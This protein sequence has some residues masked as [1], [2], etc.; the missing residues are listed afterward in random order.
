MKE[1]FAIF[2]LFTHLWGGNVGVSPTA[3]IL[4]PSV[5][6]VGISGIVIPHH[7]I[8][9]IKRQEF[10][11]HV[12]DAFFA[13]SEPPT[14]IIVSPNHFSAGKAAIQ[15]TTKTWMLA[16]GTMEPDKITVEA[17][18]RDHIADD[19]PKDVT[20]DHGI[21]YVLADIHAVF[22]HAQIVPIIVRQ[23]APQTTIDSLDISLNTTCPSCL[24]I[25]SVDFS[26]YQP[27]AL[28]DIHDTVSV[29]ALE[30]VDGDT[31]LNKTEVDSPQALYL[32]SRWATLHNTKHFNLYGHTN[33]GVLL[34]NPD[35]ETTTH[36]FG[37][38][39]T[40]KPTVPDNSVTFT[41]AG[42]IMLA[43]G[44]ATKFGSNYQSLFAELGDRVFWGV[45]A[46]FAN[47]EGA[48]TDQTSIS[49]KV[50]SDLT[51]IFPKQALAAL[52]YLHLRAVSLANNHALNDEQKGLE[53]SRQVL[54]NANVMSF[55]D[56]RATKDIKIVH[57]DGQGYHL[58][59]IGVLAINESTFLQK[60][61]IDQIKTIKKDPTNKVLIYPHWGIEYALKHSP[62]QESLAHSW[63]DAGADAIIGTHPHV[64]QDMEAYHGRPIIYSLGNFI[65]D[66][67]TPATTQYGLIVSGK[68]TDTG[69]DLVPSPIGFH[70]M[71]PFLM[72]GIEKQTH[73]NALFSSVDKYKKDTP[74]STI[75]NFPLK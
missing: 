73:L 18:L 24:M 70:A 1:L 67:V 15:T 22:P 25:A 32:L 68:F 14:V 11:A 31:L 66:Q 71:K 54:R 65:F 33:S 69:L 30:N 2:S 41:V 75:L 21:R 40:G 60:D 53:L 64:V 72:R 13:Q 57:V 23:D 48:I 34:N 36:V 9:K 29:R 6:S 27:A 44:V 45:D 49:K 5:Q 38:Y 39:E 26:H 74:F 62:L 12:R 20:D 3:I 59:L 50:A 47:L 46:P 42:D 35:I 61:L 17:L 52:K 7:D 55:G 4:S 10:L 58:Y 63:I 56:P 37:W 51:F 16:K 19:Q 8:V 43:R 28:S